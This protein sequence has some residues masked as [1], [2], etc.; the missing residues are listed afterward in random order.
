MLR[1]VEC[2]PT[3]RSADETPARLRVEEHRPL[4]MAARSGA[5]RCRPAATGA[6]S[7]DIFPQFACLAALIADVQDR[8]MEL[9]F[10]FRQP[11]DAPAPDRLVG[12]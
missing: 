7:K 10:P 6:A 5:E 8:E 4:T 2:L 12:E 3:L 11:T 1:I 9:M